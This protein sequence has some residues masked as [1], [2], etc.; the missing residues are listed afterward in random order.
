M[1]YG[2]SHG[3]NILSTKGSMVFFI[4]QGSMVFLS[5]RHDGADAVSSHVMDEKMG[6]GYVVFV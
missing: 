6:A 5:S 1:G 3:W 4:K 2:K